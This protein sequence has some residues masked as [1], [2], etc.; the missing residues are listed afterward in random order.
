MNS[1]IM[2]LYKVVS[3]VL[4]IDEKQKPRR[5]VRD[6]GKF[7]RESTSQVFLHATRL[8]L[9]I[10]ACRKF[11][12]VASHALAPGLGA[13]VCFSASPAGGF[14]R[15]ARSRHAGM[16]L[17]AAPVRAIFTEPFQCDHSPLTRSLSSVIA[18]RMKRKCPHWRTRGCQRCLAVQATANVW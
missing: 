7:P 6:G 12:L 1:C 3:V 13:K 4:R 16:K 2:V 17:D 14:I 11:D 18:K 10:A 15:R 9:K 8:A 5:A